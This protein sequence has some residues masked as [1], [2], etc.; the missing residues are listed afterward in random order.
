MDCFGRER[1]PVAA[2]A[3]FVANDPRGQLRVLRRSSRYVQ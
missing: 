2:E 3:L 1:R